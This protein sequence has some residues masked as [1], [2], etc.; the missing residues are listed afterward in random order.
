MMKVEVGVEVA[1]NKL[2]DAVWF[3][4]EACDGFILTVRE[5]GTDF[6]TQRI[7]ASLVKQVRKGQ[8]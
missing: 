5:A 1:F 8:G 7:D 4:V 2:G 6:A 3:T